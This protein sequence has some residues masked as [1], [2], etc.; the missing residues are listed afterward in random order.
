MRDLAQ[1]SNW[2]VLFWWLCDNRWFVSGH[3]W[4]QDETSHAFTWKGKSCL[5]P[6]G[7]GLHSNVHYNRFVIFWMSICS[8]VMNQLNGH[9]GHQILPPW[10]FPSGAT[11]IPLCAL[12]RF[13]T[14]GFPFFLL[15]I[16]EVC[17]RVN[18]EIFERV[19]RNFKFYI[20]I[21]LEPHSWHLEH[22]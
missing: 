19:H 2:T 15:R 7:W 4:Q 20:N 8:G 11:L 21:C 16:A 3:A 22:L 12:K 6:V 9:H 14:K 17:E 13:M 1:T 5:V 18:G 10:T